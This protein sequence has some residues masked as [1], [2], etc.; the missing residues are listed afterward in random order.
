MGKSQGVIA[1]AGVATLDL[2]IGGERRIQARCQGCGHSREIG[3]SELRD[4]RDK[5]GGSFSL[6]GRRGRC[7]QSQCSGRTRFHYYNAFWWGLWTEA[8][9]DRWDAIARRD[10]ARIRTAPETGDGHALAPPH[11]A[12]RTVR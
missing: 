3:L 2:I 6:I 7:E 8:D 12:P 10:G 4:L 9:S 1:L 11:P 5:V